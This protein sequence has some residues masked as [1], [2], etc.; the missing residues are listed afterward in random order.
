MTERKV[1]ELLDP[2]KILFL[3]LHACSNLFTLQNSWIYAHM[4]CD[5]VYRHESTSVCTC[6]YMSIKI[7]W[8]YSW[9]TQKER[10]RHRQREKQAPC[11]EPDVGLDPR[12]TPWAKG[13]CSTAEPLRL[14]LSVF[15]TCIYLLYFI[16]FLKVWCLVRKIVIN[17]FFQHTNI[18][19]NYFV[20]GIRQY[21][22]EWW[23][24]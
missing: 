15:L 22:Q 10:Q 13:R 8:I 24:V 4:I 5:I 12:T 19:N 3:D 6:V 9:E 7:L 21:V 20:S 23:A 11:G 18:M 1:R 14:P 2:C 16:M 17:P